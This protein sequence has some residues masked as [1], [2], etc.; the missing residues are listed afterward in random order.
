MRLLLILAS[1]RELMPYLATVDD[2]EPDCLAALQIQW[3][4]E[5]KT[6][7]VEQIDMNG[8][9]GGIRS[10]RLPDHAGVTT[11]RMMIITVPHILM[12]CGLRLVMMSVAVRTT[13]HD[14]G[15]DQSRS[16]YNQ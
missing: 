7:R 16:A 15:G 8:S 11:R 12:M 9:A 4:I 2:D 5:R 14:T 3:R 13:R 1:D 6:H 10:G